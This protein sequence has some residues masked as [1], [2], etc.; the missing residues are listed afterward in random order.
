MPSEVQRL[1]Y[2]CSLDNIAVSFGELSTDFCI[3]VS[4]GSQGDIEGFQVSS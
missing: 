4:D 3:R 2:A 1:L